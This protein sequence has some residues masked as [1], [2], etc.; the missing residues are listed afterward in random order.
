M[1][2]GVVS[3]L[4]GRISGARWAAEQT[5]SSVQQG[6]ASGGQCQG[7]SVC[8]GATLWYVE[9]SYLRSALEPA[10]VIPWKWCT[11]PFWVFLINVLAPLMQSVE[12]AQK[13]M[14]DTWLFCLTSLLASVEFPQEPICGWSRSADTAALTTCASVSPCQTRLL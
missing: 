7:R 6:R 3:V 14:G 13:P 1:G 8:H 9:V 11:P 2:K 12:F 4:K 5:K 10:S